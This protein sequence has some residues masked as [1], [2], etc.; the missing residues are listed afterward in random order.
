MLIAFIARAK[1]HFKALGRVITS[2]TIFTTGAKTQTCALVGAIRADHNHA[3]IQNLPN[4][5]SSY[6]CII[7]FQ[8]V[9]NL[10]PT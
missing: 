4:K 3:A 8:W 1:W 2:A 10:M 6:P 9:E 7:S 5:P